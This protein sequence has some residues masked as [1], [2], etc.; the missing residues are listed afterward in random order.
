MSSLQ[1]FMLDSMIFTARHEELLDPEYCSVKDIA[2]ALDD[3]Y[4]ECYEFGNELENWLENKLGVLSLDISFNYDSKKMTIAFREE[5]IDGFCDYGES[6]SKII[7]SK[8]DNKL[9]IDYAT[10]FNRNENKMLEILDSEYGESLVDFY[11]YWFKARTE[12]KRD[13]RARLETYNS[14]LNETGFYA[15]VSDGILYFSYMEE[16]GDHDFIGISLNKTGIEPPLED[17]RSIE[18]YNKN[19]GICI[20]KAYVKIHF[21]PRYLRDRLYDIRNKHILDKQS[22]PQKKL[23]IR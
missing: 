22:A 23:G 3:R 2:D 4:R 5:D 20:S 12:E 6:K 13:C 8:I 18:I 10:C 15:T 1:K 9:K 17:K 19:Y 16:I 21:L 14:N 11:D 7:L